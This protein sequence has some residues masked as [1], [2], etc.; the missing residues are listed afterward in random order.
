MHKFLKYLS[1][2]LLILL[3]LLIVISVFNYFSKTQYLIE[4]F[5]SNP[6]LTLF[7]SD[8]CGHCTK[9]K[10]EWDKFEKKYPK[11]CNKYERKDITDEM[12][13]TYGVNGYPTIV[14]IKNGEK[15][16]DYKGERDSS[17]FEEFLKEYLQ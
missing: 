4:G 7:Y 14:L 2:E 8:Q 9:M 3:L 13:N 1:V 16:K 17:S 10:P 11:N 6:Q 5:D 15:I 12:S